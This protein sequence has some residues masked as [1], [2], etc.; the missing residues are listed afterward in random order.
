M[1]DRSLC[2]PLCTPRCTLRRL[3]VIL[4]LLA[5]LVAPWAA[6]QQA[7][8]APAGVLEALPGVP[9][10]WV[11]A[12]RLAHVVGAEVVA[13]E[14]VLVLRTE[15]VTLTLFDDS[16]DGTLAGRRA[17]ETSL[18]APAERRPDGWW[19]PLDAGAPFG[20]V[21]TGP[22]TVTDARGRVWTLQ[23]RPPERTTSDD[24][25]ATV[26][27]PALGAVAVE[28]VSEPN[29]I[30]ES[31]EAVWATDLAL[32]P[33]LAPELRTVVDGALADAGSA[34]ALLIIATSRTPGASL[35]GI[36]LS[37]GGRELVATGARH[38]T[39]AGSADDVGPGSPWIAVAWLPTGTRLDLPL[40]IGWQGAAVEV[41]F[42]R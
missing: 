30:G 1:R 8:E 9:Q 37:A 15:S 6:A 20:L 24:P 40:T 11:R 2:T 19:L 32:V 12:D 4:T 10:P 41:T 21:R 34:R 22:R 25:R 38:E 33:L 26:L 7:T 14:S 35:E 13:D 42:R 36:S 27:R 5:G 23:V 39:L 28:I 16:V 31:D 3:A 18:S 29:E 17:G